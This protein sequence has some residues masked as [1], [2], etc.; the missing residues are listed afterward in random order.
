VA[1]T[2]I[3]PDEGDKAVPPG[4]R[5]GEPNEVAARLPKRGLG[6]HG[7][8]G[9]RRKPANRNTVAYHRNLAEF[10]RGQE[11]T[12]RREKFERE[13]ALALGPALITIVLSSLGLWWA[14]WW[15]VS[16]LLE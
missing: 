11:A 8:G 2:R 3:D 16:A 12:S 14:I 10:R 5:S 4:L 9:A 1:R 15:V 13:T 7:A 6:K